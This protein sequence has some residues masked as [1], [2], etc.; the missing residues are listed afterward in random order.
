M[1]NSGVSRRGNAKAYPRRSYPL[2]CLTIE[3]DMRRHLVDGIDALRRP[4]A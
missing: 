3:S 2:R 4:T 1:C